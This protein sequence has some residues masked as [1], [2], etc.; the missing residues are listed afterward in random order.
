MKSNWEKTKTT[1]LHYSVPP[2]IGGVESVINAHAAQFMAAGLPLKI[3]AGRGESSALPLG[4][5]FVRI[6]EMDSLHPEIKKITGALNQGELPEN[7]DKLT[8]SLAESLRPELQDCDHLIVHNVLTKH[9]NLPLSAAIIQLIKEGV[10]PHTIAW[11]HDL[12]WTSPHSR[13][14]VYPS[15]P[16]TL[17]KTLQKNTTYVAISEKRRAE[18]AE[19]FNCD[20]GLIPVI[21]NGVDPKTLMALSD[22]GL[23]LMDRMHL[24]NA[25]LILLMP[26]RI[27]EAKN[28]EFAMRVTRELVSEYRTVKLIVSGPPDPHDSESMKYYGSLLSLKRD[29]G[30]EDHVHFVFESGPD[31]DVGYLIQGPMVSELYRMADAMFM[32]SHR[33]GYGMPILE[34]GLLGVPIISTAVPAVQDLHLDDAL[35]FDRELEPSRLANRIVEWLD[36]KPEFRF[37]VQVRQNLT[38]KAIF[39]KQILP[40]LSMEDSQ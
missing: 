35:I 16:W 29:L 36:H 33:E 39:Q 19:S 38:W 4:V 7:F 32:P 17:L 5:E 22:E 34:A 6:P 8:Q 20:A 11:C 30:L 40:L 21:H 12:T 1:I 9:F 25:D 27:T 14:N 3:I 26:V 23:A 15:E 18:V 2:V 24:W 13:K 28:I 10:V 37:R 31:P